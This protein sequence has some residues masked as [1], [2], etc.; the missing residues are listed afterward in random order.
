[1][2]VAV[3]ATGDS[4]DTQMHRLFGRC[5]WF[6]IFDDESEEVKAWKNPYA[7]ME[8]GAG[9]GCAQDL[10]QEGIEAVIS[11]QVGPKAYEVLRQAKIGIY[12]APPDFTVQ[13]VY[14]MFLTKKLHKMEIKTF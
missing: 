9:I 3:S 1:M 4:P 12:L 6:L 10:I 11:G 5:D 2:K 8:T 7:E 14:E 13:K